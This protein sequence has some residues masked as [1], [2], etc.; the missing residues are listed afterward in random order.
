LRKNTIYGETE[1]NSIIGVSMQ[2]L[3]LFLEAIYI[4]AFI[5]EF[6]DSILF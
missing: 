1:Q 2:V 6:C 5:F 3:Q 4:A